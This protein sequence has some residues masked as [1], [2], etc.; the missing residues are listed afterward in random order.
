MEPIPPEVG[1]EDEFFDCQNCQCMLAYDASF[2]RRRFVEE[3]AR[4]FSQRLDEVESLLVPANDAGK[5]IC[6]RDLP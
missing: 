3:S 2:Y 1:W 6:S 4:L 5:A